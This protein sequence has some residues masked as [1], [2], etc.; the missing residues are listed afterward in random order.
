MVSR[1]PLLWSMISCRRSYQI[2][3]MNGDSVDENHLSQWSVMNMAV[4]EINTQD[5]LGKKKS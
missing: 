1:K 2:W 4:Y 3:S 5:S